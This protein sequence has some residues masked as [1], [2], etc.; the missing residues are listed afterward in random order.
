MVKTS[1]RV[2]KN[3]EQYLWYLQYIQVLQIQDFECSEYKFLPLT[4]L[5]QKTSETEDNDA[6]STCPFWFCNH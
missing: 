4:F 2:T 5:N 6:R 3:P 1:V